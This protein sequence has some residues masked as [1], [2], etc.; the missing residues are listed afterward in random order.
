MAVKTKVDGNSHKAESGARILRMHPS[1]EPPIMKAKMRPGMQEWLDSLLIDAV[2]DKDMETARW[3]LDNGANRNAMDHN[4]NTAVMRAVQNNGVEITGLMISRKADV[5]IKNRYGDSPLSE[6]SMRDNT[7]IAKMLLDNGADVDTRDIKGWTPLMDAAIMNHANV[8]LML[9]LS[10][11]NVHAVNNERQ[12]AWD[13]AMRFR[14]T[15]FASFLEKHGARPD[16]RDESIRVV[17][18]R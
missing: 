8:A 18:I 2:N 16:I 5:N 6:A 15:D 13:C 11:A 1:T 3:S 12:T 14:N 17:S 10:D 4:G 9:I 7:G